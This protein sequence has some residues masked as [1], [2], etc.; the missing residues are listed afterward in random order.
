MLGIFSWHVSLSYYPF[1]RQLFP[2]TGDFKDELFGKFF[3]ALDKVNFFK[4]SPDGVEDPAQ[5][6]KATKLFSDAL[7]VCTILSCIMQVTVFLCGSK[8]LTCVRVTAWIGTNTIE[9]ILKTF[10]CLHTALMYN[11]QIWNQI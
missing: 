6:A 9:Y 8:I 11:S 1:D 2:I 7:M 4:I 10:A 5:V 3:A